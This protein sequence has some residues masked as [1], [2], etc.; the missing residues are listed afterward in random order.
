MSDE[1]NTTGEAGEFRTALQEARRL[2]SALEVLTEDK[3][4]ATVAMAAC[5][6][7]HRLEPSGEHLAPYARQLLMGSAWIG[8]EMGNE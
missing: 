7:I 3:A 1:S 4:A 6:L 5:I 2:A 8:E